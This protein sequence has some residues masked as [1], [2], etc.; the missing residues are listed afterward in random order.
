M[1]RNW[2]ENY[3]DDEDE[4]EGVAG[5]EDRVESKAESPL[6]ERLEKYVPDAGAYSLETAAEVIDQRRHERKL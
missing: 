5:Q 4:W 2:E 3:W 6:D 1:A